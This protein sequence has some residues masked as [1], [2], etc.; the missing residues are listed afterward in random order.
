MRKLEAAGDDTARLA[1]LEE[2]KSL[3]WQAVWKCIVNVMIRQQVA[4]G[5]RAC[6][7]MGERFEP[8]G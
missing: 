6:G 7:L 3:P 2:Q 8:R 4:N 5:W 1:L